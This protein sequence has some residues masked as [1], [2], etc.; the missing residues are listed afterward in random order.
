MF[1]ARKSLLAFSTLLVFSQAGFGQGLGSEVSIQQ[2][3]ADGQ[4]FTVGVAALLEHGRELFTA[5]WTSQEGGGRPLTDGTGGVLSDPS[6]PLIGPRSFNRVSAPDANSCY[7]CHNAPRG[8]IGGGGDFVTS[9]FVLG[10]RFDFVTFDSTDPVP[11]RGAADEN[12][13]FPTMQ[14]I[15]N[16]RATLGM[17]GSGF[18][19]MLARQMTARLQQLRDSLAPGGQVAL[20]AK[21]ISF[22][23]LRRN[24]DG[25]WDTS[26]VSGLSAG[27]VAFAG[28]TPPSLVIKPFHQAGAVIS[29]R[30]FSNNAFNHHHGVQP[31]ERFG[32]GDVDGDGFTVEMTT[33]DVTAVSVFQAAMAVPGRVI[34]NDPVLE[35]AIRTGEE[36][37]VAM[38]CA[39][40]H[41]PYL[42]LESGGWVYSEPNP[43]NPAGNLNPND[44]YVSQFGTYSLDLTSNALPAP[45]LKASNNVV[46]VPAFTDLKLHDITSGPNDPNREACDMHQPAGSPGFL[47]GN[48][49]F[50]TKKLWGAA[51]EPPY[52]H[53]GR[54]TTLREAIEN[55]AG[56]AANSRALW[57]AATDYERNCVIEFL[58]TLRVLDPGTKSL[59]VD[60]H[61]RAKNWPAFPWSPPTY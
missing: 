5:N 32:G 33:A 49:R 40:C 23:A 17:S 19:E 57:D 55:H 38:D 37:F 35:Q 58:K 6:S 12:G 3:L 53:H 2:H 13:G 28:Q 30:Q 25:T 44:P 7:G 36:Q 15:A 10:Q 4:E 39:S 27:S 26:Q 21:G 54:F 8:L 18:V 46:R 9:V 41:T 29:L 52:F 31:S 51:N 14:E 34:P 42:K 56:E 45:R 20:T 60:E 59:V 22:G 24:Q 16:S 43:F 11:L 1:P 47:A 50:L 61:G 48:S